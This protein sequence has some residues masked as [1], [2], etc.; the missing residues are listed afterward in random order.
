MKE[1][2]NL[3]REFSKGASEYGQK[4]IIDALQDLSDAM[5]GQTPSQEESDK[6]YFSKD[7]SE[8]GQVLIANTIKELADKVN[9]GGGGGSQPAAN[10]DITVNLVQSENQTISVESVQQSRN[11]YYDSQD[12]FGDINTSI[13]ASPIIVKPKYC[14]QVSI[15]GGDGYDNGNIIASSGFVVQ[16]EPYFKVYVDEGSEVTIS[17]TPATVRQKREVLSVDVNSDQSF[18]YDSNTGHYTVGEGTANIGVNIA[19]SYDTEDYYRDNIR[20]SGT[21]SG[22]LLN[23]DTD[24]QVPI[25]FPYGDEV[26]S[27]HIGYVGV[28]CP[29]LFRYYASSPKYAASGHYI[30]TFTYSGDNNY[31]PKDVQFEFYVQ[32]V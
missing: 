9:T 2:S 21:I 19:V 11:C 14:I 20:P 28:D 1:E 6:R 10:K 16:N 17:A 7:A 31:L 26:M 15:R 30:A 12:H 23:V 25:P 22:T 3:L 18:T 13:T 8:Y 24:E 27:G 4:L 5:S 29:D 32:S